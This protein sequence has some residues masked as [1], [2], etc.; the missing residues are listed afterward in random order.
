MKS[1]PCGISCA[2]CRFNINKQCQCRF[3]ENTDSFCE[4]AHSLCPVMQCSTTNNITF[5]TRDCGDFPCL[6]LERTIPYRWSLLSTQ[7]AAGTLAGW[8]P[9][10][11]KVTRLERDA[12]RVFC[13]GNFHVFRGS[14]KLQDHHWS[15]GR[16]PTQ[17]IKAFF[18]FLL[19]REDRGARKDTIIDLL[20][21]QQTNPQRA[22]SSFH[23]ALFYLRRALEPDITPNNA[24]SYIQHRG[25]RYYFAP[26]NPCW[27]DTDAFTFYTNRALALEHGGSAT[28]VVYWEK[29]IDLYRGQFLTGIDTKYTCSEFYDWCTPRCAHFEQ[30][31]LTAK[32]AVARH[33]LAFEQY[34]LAMEHAREILC[35][36][37][38]FEQAQHFL[39]RCLSEIVQTD[40]PLDPYC[41]GETD[42]VIQTNPSLSILTPSL[43][44]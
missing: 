4:A 15:N 5:C 32:M 6:L 24:S 23:Q 43:D 1:G 10:T 7:S 30:L 13:L 41:F 29:A 21:P 28:A 35:I 40:N 31:F 34:D 22:T 33:H 36:E 16:G 42:L 25:N 17:K 12:L 18:A 38:A 14:I 44:Q 27:I 3:A 9:A 2:V 39:T 26:K 8:R 37:P 11:P 20:W 19:F